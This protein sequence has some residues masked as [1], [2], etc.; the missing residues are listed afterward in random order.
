MMVRCAAGWV[1]LGAALPLWGM[2]QGRGSEADTL[3]YFF[4]PET[5]TGPAGAKTLIAFAKV[6]HEK[7]RIRPVVLIERW[8]G[9]RKVTPEPVLWKTVQELG[10][11]REPAGVDIPLYDVEGL[12]LA[13]AWKIAR[14]P[15]F[16]LVSRG[17]A[18]LVHGP[19][20][21]LGSLVG[22]ER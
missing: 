11:L 7:L 9:L 19:S 21:D 5:E 3:Y 8:E 17:R 18:H 4:S 14:L 13:K 1:A 12:A 2:T 20:A 16:V 22:C 15:A 10:R 6:G